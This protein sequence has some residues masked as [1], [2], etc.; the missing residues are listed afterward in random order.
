MIPKDMQVEMISVEVISIIVATSPT[1]INSVTLIIFLSAS[2][3]AISSSDLN[4]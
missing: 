3:K 2:F 4:L 1:V